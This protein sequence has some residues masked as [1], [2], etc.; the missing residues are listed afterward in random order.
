M[1][2]G[3]ITLHHTSRSCGLCKWHSAHL[4]RAGSFSNDYEHYC[5][6]ADAPYST[7][8]LAGILAH[9]RNERRPGSYIGESDYTPDWCPV[10][11][12]VLQEG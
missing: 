11:N 3:P 10:A 9:L 6:H 1:M 2:E 12:S 8:G 7:D 5:T 4:V